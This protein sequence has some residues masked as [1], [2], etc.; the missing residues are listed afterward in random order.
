MCFFGLLSV[1]DRY[2]GGYYDRYLTE[3]RHLFCIALAFDLQLFTQIPNDEH[4]LIPDM[5][6]TEVEILKT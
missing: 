5:I 2:G 1:F 3:H 4:D 6:I